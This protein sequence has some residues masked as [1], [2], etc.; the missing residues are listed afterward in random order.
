MRVQDVCR[1]EV[2][3]DGYVVICESGVGSNGTQVSELMNI[4]QV[5]GPV[6]YSDG[7]CYLLLLLLSIH[8]SKLYCVIERFYSEIVCFL[9]CSYCAKYTQLICIRI[10]F[11]VSVCAIHTRVSAHAQLT[12]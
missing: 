9:S 2:L 10:A 8:E 12:P 11:V 7:V 3:G 1:A 5:H 6:S 4:H